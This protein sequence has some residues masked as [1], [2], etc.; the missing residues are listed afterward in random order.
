MIKAYMHSAATLTLVR[1]FSKGGYADASKLPSWTLS[2]T[3]NE[4]AAEYRKMA[5]QIRDAIE[6]YGRIEHSA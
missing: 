3:E 2:F 6:F 1:A 5:N 4:R